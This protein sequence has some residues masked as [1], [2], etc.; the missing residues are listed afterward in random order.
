MPVA[1]FF[2]IKGKVKEILVTTLPDFEVTWGFTKRDVPRNWC[3]LGSL[4]WPSD[5]WSTNKSREYEMTVPIILNAIRPRS[6]PEEAEA[7]LAPQVASVIAAF[8]RHSEIRDAGVITW[9]IRPRDFRSQPHADGIEAQAALELS[10][11][12]R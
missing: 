9:G 11:T 8:E 10:V 7:W 6:T 12:Y 5:E 2:A 3:Y 4:N 1:D